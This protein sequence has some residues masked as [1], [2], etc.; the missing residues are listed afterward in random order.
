MGTT[1]SISH[2][3]MALFSVPI[4]S[5]IGGLVIDLASAP[6]EPGDHELRIETTVGGIEIYLPRHVTF[7]VNGSPM[8]GGQDVHDGHGLANRF[9]RA[10]GGLFGWHSSIPDSAVPSPDPSKPTM[11]R[12]TVDAGIGGIDIYRI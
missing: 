10:L 9:G 7:M 11:I 12:I 5:T 1:H 8:I 2:S 3:G 6:I 4:Q